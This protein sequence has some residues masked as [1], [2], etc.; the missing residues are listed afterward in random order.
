MKTGFFFDK[1]V[2]TSQL[3]LIVRKNNLNMIGFWCKDSLNST[4]PLLYSNE[5]E[6]LEK[7]EVAVLFLNGSS[8]FELA[9]KALKSGI[10]LFL[11][12]L[13]DYT[14]QALITLNELSLE[15]GR[16]IGFGCSGTDL[17][18]PGEIINNY[19]MIQMIRDAGVETDDET[20]R[21]MLVYDIAS[22]VRLKPCSLRKMRV[23][24]VP[25]FN[26]S[27]K[28]FNLRLEYDNSGIIAYSLTRVNGPKRCHFRFFSGDDGHFN[29]LPVDHVHLDPKVLANP[30]ALLNDNDFVKGLQGFLSELSHNQRASFN[31]DN[32]LETFGFIKT[33]EERLYPVN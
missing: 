11:T 25:L 14:Y 15:I 28:A 29:D 27:P 12:S 32:A 2:D 17:V 19:F 18:K 23:N 5:D 33:V 1:E 20:F 16:Q 3:D 24:G 8:Y 31:I 13:P 21:R 22:F 30:L 7:V 6:L 26:K 4:N 10:N 9:S